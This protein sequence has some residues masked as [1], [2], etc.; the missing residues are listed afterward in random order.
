MT[1]TIVADRV[2]KLS[3]ASERRVIDPDRDVPG[4]VGLRPAPA[5]RAPERGRP[6]AS[7]SPR[8]SG[9]RCHVKRWVDHRSRDPLRSGARGRLRPADRPEHEPA[10]SPHHLLLHEIGEETRHQRLF[11]RMLEQ[12][13]P[14]AKNPF[15]N[16][17]TRCLERLRHPADHLACR[18]CCTCLVLGGEEIPDLFQKLASEH[19][20][21][22][23]FIKRGEQ[24]P[25]HGGSPAPVVRPGEAARGLGEGESIDRLAVRFVAPIIIKG[26]STRSCTP[27]STRPW[28]CRP[29]TPGSGSARA[30]PVCVGRR[31]A[32]RPVLDAVIEAG[33][34]RKN[35]RPQG[36][37]QAGRGR[38]PPGAHAGH[39]LSAFARMCCVGGP[40]WTTYTRSGRVASASPA[41]L[42]ACR[43]T[44]STAPTSCSGTS[45]PSR[46]TSPTTGG[47]WPPPG[48]S[49][50]PSCRYSR[51][52]PPTSAWPPT[53]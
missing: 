32:T 20:D 49:S 34:F 30:T 10:R 11:L 25:P 53:T 24:V 1:N 15:V 17:V 7:I 46:R 38:V 4:D 33:A 44:W 8:I 26:C 35:R 16:R 31:K 3:T 50:A 19:P 29:W 42:V 14:N 28:V 2:R 43:F 12:M 52:A 39:R 41:T 40:I 22:D 13:Q 5:R 51:V 45:S 23:P 27:A 37:A 6:R 48:V 21:T 36:L 9:P 47:R 18:P